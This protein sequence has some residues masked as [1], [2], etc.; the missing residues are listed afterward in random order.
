MKRLLGLAAAALLATAPFH[1]AMAQDAAGEVAADEGAMAAGAAP[2][3]DATA[4]AVHIVT[5][6]D[7]SM[8]TLEGDAAF[9]M[10]ATGNKVPAADGDHVLKDGN[11]M[12]V[13]GGHVTAGM[14]TTFDDAAAPADG[15]APAEGAAPAP[16]EGAPAEAPAAQ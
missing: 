13:M 3:A 4:P 2:V 9:V 14:P 10:D 1:T 5:L 7:G 15:A 12:T 11:V 16:A 8:V 6:M